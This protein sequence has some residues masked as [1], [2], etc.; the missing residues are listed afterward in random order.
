MQLALDNRGGDG[1]KHKYVYDIRTSANA[2]RT[3]INFTGVDSPI[4]EKF[5]LR[6]KEYQYEDDLVKD[7]I[8]KHGCLP[9]GYEEWVFTYFHITTSA[10]QCSSFKKHGILDLVH[11]YECEDSELHAFLDDKNIKIDIENRMLSYN[12]Q[13]YDISFGE[14]PPRF[15]RTAYACWS[16][17]R[18]LYYDFTTCGFLSIW[19]AHPYGGY[20]H[21][22]PE[23]LSDIDN[24][25]NL[26]LSNEWHISHKPYKIVATVQGRDIVYDGDDK[27]SIE[28]KV[29][30]YL[31]KAYIT[32]FGAPTEH[33]LLM[34]NGVQILPEGII[35]I[36]PLECWW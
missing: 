12:Q 21:W 17:G 28:N 2:L 15:D 22:R 29:L 23:I 20:V 30:N 16:I 36:S 33:I 10:N 24:L 7:V 31:T 5:I 26:T 14:C 32:A 8:Q 34:K 3:L 25:L 18:K 9:A 13:T 4:W 19:D 11:S 27:Q 6:R 35:E 1:M